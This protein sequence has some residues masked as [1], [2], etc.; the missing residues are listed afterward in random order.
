MWGNLKVRCGWGHSQI[1]T[2]WLACATSAAAVSQAACPSL[3]LGQLWASSLKPKRPGESLATTA[4][5]AAPTLLLTI[6]VSCLIYSCSL[7]KPSAQIQS[8]KIFLRRIPLVPTVP[9]SWLSWRIFCLTLCS[10]IP[11]GHRV[12]ALASGLHDWS[13]SAVRGLVSLH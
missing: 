4:A 13:A 5:A 7:L 11:L 3:L 12:S 1:R 9:V 6:V 8:A 10:V 2:A